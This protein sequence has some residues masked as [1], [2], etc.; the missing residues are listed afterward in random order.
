MSTLPFCY[1]YTTILN[2]T[3]SYRHFHT[4][5]ASPV[6]PLSFVCLPAR[7]LVSVCPS[8]P[9]SVICLFVTPSLSPSVSRACAVCTLLPV[10][11][12]SVCLSVF[13]SV[14]LSYFSP[15]FCCLFALSFSLL[16]SPSL[17]RQL[18]LPT[19]LLHLG[20]FREETARLITSI[21][22]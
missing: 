15:Y 10:S 5:T 8:P 12:L 22:R 7:Q 21:R 19:C 9:T 20:N 6:P 2:L 18:L 3:S 11:L 16:F 4:S 17:Y 1:V 13:L 14:C